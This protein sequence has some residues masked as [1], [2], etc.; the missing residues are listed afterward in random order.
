MEKNTL[1]PLYKNYEGVEKVFTSGVLNIAP[2]KI[3]GQ[4]KLVI[5]RNKKLYLDDYCGRRVSVDTSVPFPHQV[6]NFLSVENNLENYNKLKYGA[7]SETS[8]KSYHI[9]LYFG[10]LDVDTVLPRFFC[11]ANVPNETISKTDTEKL[12]NYGNLLEVIDFEKIGITNIFQEIIDEKYFNYPV[13]FNFQDNNIKIFGQ[14]I[15]EGYPVCHTIDITNNMANQTYMDVLDNRILNEFLEHKMFYPRFLNIEVEFEFSSKTLPFNNFFGF[16]SY[17]NRINTDLPEIQNSPKLSANQYSGYV[18]YLLNQESDWKQIK[19]GESLIN[20]KHNIPSKSYDFRVSEVSDKPHKFRFKTSTFLTDDS[21]TIKDGSKI[22][23]EFQIFNTDHISSDIF[24]NWYKVCERFTRQ[25]NYD[26]TFKCKRINQYS[27]EISIEYFSEPDVKPYCVDIPEYYLD[28]DLLEL[29]S[30]INQPNKNIFKTQNSN[31]CVSFE[32]YQNQYTDQILYNIFASKYKRNIELHDCLL[33]PNERIFKDIELYKYD[34]NLN[35]RI[36]SDTD[37]KLINIDTYLSFTINDVPNYPV[38]LKTVPLWVPYDTCESDKIYDF[39]DYKNKLSK[40]YSDPVFEQ[41]L[42]SFKQQEIPLFQYVDYQTNQDKRALEQDLNNEEKI[43]DVKFSTVGQT[44]YN[45]VHLL[46]VDEQCWNSN[47]CPDV[48]KINKDVL[49]FAWFSLI[50]YYPENSYRN[51]LRKDNKLY[52]NTVSRLIR[53]SDSLCETIY[54]GVKYQLPIEYVNWY[55]AVVLNWQDSEY[56][57]FTCNVS[58]DSERKLVVLNLNKYID[59][60]D[61]IRGGN[62]KLSGVMNLSVLYNALSSMNYSSDNINSFKSCGLLL[63]QW[64]D[65]YLLGDGGSREKLLNLPLFRGQPQKNWIVNDGDKNRQYFCIRRDTVNITSGTNDF[66]LL[67]ELGDFPDTNSNECYVYN[68]IKINGETKHYKSVTFKFRNI[69]EIDRDYFWC[70]NI[71]VKFFNSKKIYIQNV[72]D[73]ISA[74]I[75]LS[76]RLK[77][78]GNIDIFDFTQ[79]AWNSHLVE[80]DIFGVRQIQ[81]L[82]TAFDFKKYYFEIIQNAS[83]SKDGKQTHSNSVWTFKDGFFRNTSV[84]T[85]FKAFYEGTSNPDLFEI[86]GKQEVSTYKWRTTLFEHNQLW[87][88]LRNLLKYGV[89]FKYQTSEQLQLYFE[90]FMIQK[91]Q[92]KLKE[93]IRIEGSSNEY[94]SIKT[95]NSDVNSVIW[96]ISKNVG[97]IEKRIVNINRYSAPYFPHFKELSNFFDFQINAYQKLG[98]ILNCF[99]SNFGSFLLESTLD[100]NISN[101]GFWNDLQGN[102]VSSLFTLQDAF[103][104]Q[105]EIKNNENT[106]DYRK[107]M[108]QYFQYADLIISH[109]NTEY[110]NDLKVNI[111]KFTLETFIDTLLTKYYRLDSIINELNERIYFSFTQQPNVIEFKN[112]NIYGN[113][114]TN[115][116]R[117]SFRFV[118]K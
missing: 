55:F 45:T 31:N 7:F 99:D 51:V 67:F 80:T 100:K 68:E 41:A 113:S 39:E 107:L 61:L 88:M 63:E 21:I 71:E 53:I 83:D 90:D 85:M 9:P 60:S 13:Y 101:T 23:G 1:F 116:S 28:C 73:E 30:T 57:D 70:E 69:V 56:T 114:V 89:I 47:G 49:R 64:Y 17:D 5:A 14:G 111:I 92:Q 96:D 32:L 44:A 77:S 26:F 97:T 91:L 37:K 10:N 87:F 118:R 22:L 29:S 50:D 35:L 27:V 18:M 20:E 2:I 72:N 112:P 75:T 79:N 58:V 24:D 65:G 82:D 33:P 94:I 38:L 43:L 110:I 106:V 66:T 78:T 8:I 11:V 12:Y 42:K 74:N 3:S 48:S 109:P 19:I 115:F 102:C 117:L 86:N 104:I 15:N 4:Y 36:I 6:S 25:S 103:E 46:N 59:F 98:T 105:Y 34:G 95:I 54:F 40:T 93:H 108:F 76:D 16:V 84:E 62:P 81:L 52:P